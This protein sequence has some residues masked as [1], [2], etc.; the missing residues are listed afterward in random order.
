M[1]TFPT[2]PADLFRFTTG[3]NA[4]L[5]TAVLHAFGEANERLETALTLDDVH[6]EL[7]RNHRPVS[8]EE[9][10]SALRSLRQWGLVDTVQHHAT[11]YTSADDYERENLRHVLTR[12]GEAATAAA[13]YARKIIGSTGV[14]EAAHLDAIADRLEEL[15]T[16]D[17]RTYAAL[18]ELESHL[19]AFQTGVQL[20]H[21]ELKRVQTQDDA[22]RETV[23]HLQTFVSDLDARKER[24]RQTLALIDAEE[25]RE[26]ALKSAHVRDE[27]QWLQ[28]RKDA[29]AMLT[30]WFEEQRID[31]LEDIARTVIVELLR[32]LD[33]ISEQR[34]KPTNTAADFRALASWFARTN[35][36]DEAHELF[37]AAFGLWP[38][39]HAHLQHADGELIPSAEPWHNT[40]AVPVSPQLRRTGKQ[41]HIGATG[42]VRDVE[43]IRRARKEQAQRE[44]HELEL[45]WQ[46]L[47]TDGPIRISSLQELDHDAFD[48]LLDLVGRALAALPDSTGTRA[49]STSDGRVHIRLRNAR[50]WAKITTQRG[51][52]SGPDYVIEVQR[53]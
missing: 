41:E 30:A 32:A 29:W 3:P 40:P 26:R 35:N 28:Q 18:L 1:T 47:Q 27:L 9:L 46:Q 34:R 4:E 45:A 38:A 6:H 25:V 16:S 17:V 48:R 49:A 52:L 8:D 31:E 13:R 22:K 24:I 23:A 2:V 7:R 42:K 15:R 33:R 37:N 14:L 10:K 51:T 11:H 12:R 53:R 5:H 36:D 44:R 20:F 39:R 21:G 50:G 19:D 43:Q